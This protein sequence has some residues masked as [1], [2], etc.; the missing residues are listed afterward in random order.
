MPKAGS[1]AALSARMSAISQQRSGEAR[2]VRSAGCVR[3]GL[4]AA[5]KRSG[6]PFAESGEGGVDVGEFEQ[7]DLGVADGEA[8]AVFVRLLSAGW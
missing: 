5:R 7:T 4:R 8:E 6:P 3:S 2:T 1:R